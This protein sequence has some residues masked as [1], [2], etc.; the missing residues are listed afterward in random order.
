VSTEG[1]QSAAPAVRVD[2]VD[3]RRAATPGEWLITW[4]I[5]N[6]DRVPI[7]V[8]AAWLP[9]GKFRGAERAF[10]PPLT[11]AAAS[12]TELVLAA[13]CAEPPG[14]LVENAFVILRVRAQG[15]CWRVLTRLVVVVDNPDHLDIQRQR[16]TFQRVGFSA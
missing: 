3:V 5:D 6:E 16:V 12:S 7:T 2:V 15:I 1:G 14:A 13:R 4:R 11:I 9:H 10:D 8:T